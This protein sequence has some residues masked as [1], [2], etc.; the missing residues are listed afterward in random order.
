V[1]G[2]SGVRGSVSHPKPTQETA[3]LCTIRLYTSIPYA[4]IQPTL[5]EHTIIMHNNNYLIVGSCYI[6]LFNAI[7]SLV[8]PLLFSKMKSIIQHFLSIIGT[9]MSITD[10]FLEQC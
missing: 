1:Y 9:L 8:L 3:F 6:M 10:M 2:A 5:T 7:L 4:S